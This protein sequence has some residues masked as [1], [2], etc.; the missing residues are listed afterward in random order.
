M[1]LFDINLT[2]PQELHD[3]GR[4]LDLNFSP[5]TPEEQEEAAQPGHIQEEEDQEEAA[6]P[7]HIQ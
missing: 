4:V 2:P 5:H 6:Q 1:V 3:G 7:G